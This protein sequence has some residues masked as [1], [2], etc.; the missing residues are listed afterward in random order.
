MGMEGNEEKSAVS[1]ER[2]QTGVAPLFA[3]AVAGFSCL[4]GWELSAVF[5]PSLP[6][7]AFCDIQ[8][9]IFVRCISVLTLATAFGL[10]AW[11]AD[12]F[13]VNR[14]RLVPF[15]LATS[16]LPMACACVHA[17][18][19]G[20]PLIVLEVSWALLGVSQAVLSTYWCVFFQSC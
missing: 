19:G 1:S 3:V 16:L 4:I 18:T 2:R 7:L 20:L 5:S 13:F 10:F 14:A 8:T 17:A 9:A 6:L 11:K 12:W 15:A